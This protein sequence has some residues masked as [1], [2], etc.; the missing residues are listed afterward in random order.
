MVGKMQSLFPSTRALI[1]KDSKCPHGQAVKTSPSHGGIWG[2]IP[3]G[4]TK[5][6]Y[7]NVW[8][9]FYQMG[10]CALYARNFVARTPE[11]WGG[12]RL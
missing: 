5:K 8:D 1:I 7:T 12:V 11:I 6:S 4:G 9:F 10:N 2:S 3:H